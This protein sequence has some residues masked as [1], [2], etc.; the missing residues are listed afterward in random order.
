[1]WTAVWFMNFT[2]GKIMITLDCDVYVLLKCIYESL[3]SCYRS[4][5]HN[6]LIIIGNI[7]DNI[8]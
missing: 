6:I 1:M 2:P 4:E 8:I 5:Q 3:P 7:V